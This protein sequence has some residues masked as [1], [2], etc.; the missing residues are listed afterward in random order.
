MRKCKA[1]VTYKEHTDTISHYYT[2]SC[3][4]VLPVRGEHIKLYDENWDTV[5]NKYAYQYNS[6]Q[7]IYRVVL[8]GLKHNN[9]CPIKWS[10]FDFDWY[11]IYFIGQSDMIPRLFSY[12]RN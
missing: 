8:L 9:F 11:E 6:L 7:A 2:L 12:K 4:E 10:S 1:I 3:V 5:D